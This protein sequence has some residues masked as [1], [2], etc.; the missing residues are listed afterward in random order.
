MARLRHRGLK[1]LAP[2]RRNVQLGSRIGLSKVNRRSHRPNKRPV[3]L[4]VLLL[5]SMI[6][7]ITRNGVPKKLWLGL[8]WRMQI[9]AQPMTAPMLR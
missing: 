9:D 8:T 6:G 4:N 2:L 5:P 1:L 3:P 7:L